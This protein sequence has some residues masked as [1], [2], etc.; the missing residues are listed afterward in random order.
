MSKEL[1]Q[2][3]KEG[4]GCLIVIFIILVIAGIIE[5]STLLLVILG[6]VILVLL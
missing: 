1:D 3:S 6:L 4:C 2:D 5:P